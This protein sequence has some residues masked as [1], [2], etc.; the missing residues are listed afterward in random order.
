LLILLGDRLSGLDR[1]Y[2]Q[3]LAPLPYKDDDNRNGV[4]KLVD[5]VG[6]SAETLLQRPFLG[7]NQEMSNSQKEEIE[8]AEFG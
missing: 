1:R 5:K 6:V 7:V 8:E 4:Q 2:A 3:S